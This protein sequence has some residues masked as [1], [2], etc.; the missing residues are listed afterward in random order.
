MPRRYFHRKDA[1]QDE[2]VDTLRS[3]GVR[4]H[5]WGEEADLIV[6]YG[7]MTMLCEVRPEGH[8]QEARKGRQKRFQEHFGVRWL[9]T[10]DDCVEL[11]KVLRWQDQTLRE[12]KTWP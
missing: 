2:M 10:V 3:L 7:G 6:Q 1:N 11:A 4:V 5:C 12:A 9:Q 8:A